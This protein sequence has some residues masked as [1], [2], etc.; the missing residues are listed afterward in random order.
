MKA[1]RIMGRTFKST[2]EELFL[3]V[4]LS[5][6]WW[7]G[8]LLLVTAPMT[9]VGL[10][11]V[12]NRIANHKRSNTGFFWEGARSH[13]GRGVLLFLLAVLAPPLIWF[14]ITFYLQVAGWMTVPGR[15]DGLVSDYLCN[16]G[17]I[18]V[19]VV[20]AAGIAGTGPHHSKCLC[21]GVASP[22]L[23]NADAHLSSFSDC[24][25]CCVGCPST[26]FAARNDRPLPEPCTG[27][28]APGNGSRSSPSRNIWNLNSILRQSRDLG[29]GAECGLLQLHR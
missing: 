1:F 6:M 9:T 28:A 2:Y 20:L 29:C 23:Y 17:S 5:V 14:S 11:N 15:S 24:P 22:T 21:A 25:E 10:Q 13:I 18:P 8:T 16:G 26:T 12:A 3:I 27:R 4:M 7:I 19:S